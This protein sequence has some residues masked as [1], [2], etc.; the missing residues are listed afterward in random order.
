MALELNRKWKRW[1][2]KHRLQ[3]ELRY[4]KRESQRIIRLYGEEGALV[5][6]LEPDRW[7]RFRHILKIV[8]SLGLWKLYRKLV[9]KKR[10]EI[11]Q[12]TAEQVAS[13]IAA[14]EEALAI[15][16]LGKSKRALESLDRRVGKHLG[17][18]RK[19]T[20]REYAESIGVAILIA[21]LLRAFVVEAFKIP[22]GSMIPTLE[23][24]DH[25]FVNKFSY[26]LRVPFT[27]DPPRH[28]LNWGEIKRGDVVVFINRKNTEH[29]FIKRIIAKG[30][31]EVKVQDGTIYLRR[32]GKG[33][34]KKIN[35][36]RLSRPC[37]YQ[38]F[39][40]G[41]WVRRNE[42]HYWAES[43]G[44]EHYLTIVDTDRENKDFPPLKLYEETTIPVGAFQVASKSVINPYRVPPGSVFVM[45][46]N[47]TNSG[48]SRYPVQVGF[49]EREYIKG[50]AL[51]VWSS[52]GPS[53]SWW[54]LRWNRIGH[55]IH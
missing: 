40:R 6:A 54:G 28:F 18:A 45:G 23:V 32:G 52:W 17:F 2:R 39:E 42:C 5:G 33:T 50:K 14:V 9:R 46:D 47:R 55:V 8:F 24:G 53:P 4:L 48:D 7:M 22:S 15:P 41:L 49:V 12:D 27:T 3:R 36:K 25:I 35:R 11:P 43:L 1:R 38:D 31:D 26:G 16:R 44:G 51:V 19:S 30:G 13:D 34:W 37:K 29:D 20:F 21:L 10:S